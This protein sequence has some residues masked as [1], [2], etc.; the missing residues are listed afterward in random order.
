MSKQQPHTL[1]RMHGIVITLTSIN[2]VMNIFTE[3]RSKKKTQVR[4]AT[5]NFS[6]FAVITESIINRQ[7][8]LTRN[9]SAAPATADMREQAKQRSL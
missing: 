4:F 1:Q 5:T 3:S 9:K 2:D 7:C 6:V 8:R